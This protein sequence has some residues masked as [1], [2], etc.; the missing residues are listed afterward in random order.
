VR[1]YDATGLE[2]DEEYGGRAMSWYDKHKHEY[3][4]N[5]PERARQTKDDAGWKCE[6]CLNPHGPLPYVLTVHHVFHDIA[7]PDA[8]LVA[9]CA[10]CHLRCQG[11]RPRPAT[12]DEAIRRL[13]Q[14]YEA[15]QGQLG[16]PMEAAS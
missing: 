6:A 7:N 10:R 1:G 4:D 12:K 8:V 14:R 11:L 2:S 3:A 15:E 16:L 13:R 5:W 9:L